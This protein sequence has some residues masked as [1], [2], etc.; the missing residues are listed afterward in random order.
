MFE[1]SDFDD[2][3]EDKDVQVKTVMSSNDLLPHVAGQSR[4]PVDVIGKLL[5]V[6]CVI[7]RMFVE[8][9][10]FCVDHKA[11]VSAFMNMSMS[12]LRN[13]ERGAGDDSSDDNDR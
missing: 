4:G 5:D 1:W 3:E 7:V 2:N 9:Y 8:V 6:K 12:E 11:E 10:H 13:I